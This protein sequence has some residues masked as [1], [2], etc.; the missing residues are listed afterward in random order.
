MKIRLHQKDDIQSK[1]II[2]ESWINKNK[3]PLVSVIMP[4][5]NAEKYLDEAIQSILNQT[6]KDL[7]L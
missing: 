6:F 2:C 1:N 5:Y 4:V 7:L 3:I